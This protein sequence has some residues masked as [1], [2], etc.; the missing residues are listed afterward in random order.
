MLLKVTFHVA[1][2][3]VCRDAALLGLW[4]KILEEEGNSRLASNSTCSVCVSGFAFVLVCLL[5]SVWCA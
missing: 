4:E 3:D 1:V 5:R 2:S